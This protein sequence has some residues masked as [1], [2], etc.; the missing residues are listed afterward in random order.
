MDG[1]FWNKL[2]VEIN[3]FFSSSFLLVQ[4][5]LLGMRNRRVLEYSWN[6]IV[7]E[8]ACI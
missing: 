5:F 1:W 3:F 8:L 4:F 7:V 2:L 6:I